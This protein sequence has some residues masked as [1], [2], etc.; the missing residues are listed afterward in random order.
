M[1]DKFLKK[2]VAIIKKILD[3]ISSANDIYGG[4]WLNE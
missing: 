2:I 1:M 4:Y 3:V